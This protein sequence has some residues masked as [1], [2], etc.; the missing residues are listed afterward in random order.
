MA[1]HIFAACK[2]CGA[3][4]R[5]NLSAAGRRARCGKCGEA[6][7]VPDKPKTL[8]D[9]VLLWLLQDEAKEARRREKRDQ[10]AA[11]ELDI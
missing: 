8:D 3:E 1:E 9:T 5:L 4:Y 10:H 2:Y 11:V 7:R 6:F